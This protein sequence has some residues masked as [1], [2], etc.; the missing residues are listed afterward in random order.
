MSSASS[1]WEKLDDLNLVTRAPE[2]GN[3]EVVMLTVLLSLEVTRYRSDRKWLYNT[4]QDGIF[5]WTTFRPD[6]L[7]HTVL[8]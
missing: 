7:K 4:L 5:Q 2:F 1:E 6:I 8:W 3:E